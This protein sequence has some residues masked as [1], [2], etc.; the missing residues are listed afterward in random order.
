MQ[1][2]CEARVAAHYSAQPRKRLC[3]RIRFFWP[4]VGAL[5]SPTVSR[6]QVKALNTDFPVSELIKL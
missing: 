4:A 1:K 6:C 5:N 3:T 2:A